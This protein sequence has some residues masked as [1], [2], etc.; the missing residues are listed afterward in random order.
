MKIIR[1]A[2]FYQTACFVLF[3]HATKRILSG[4]LDSQIRQRT[5][6]PAGF[7][8]RV[9]SPCFRKISSIRIRCFH[10]RMSLL[11]SDSS[12]WYK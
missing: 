11:R 5:S 9:Q 1:L 7:G 8:L 10:L 3:E 12:Y 2:L 4:L 6:L